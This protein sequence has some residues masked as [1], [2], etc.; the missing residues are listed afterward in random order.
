MSAI[1]IS[2][3]TRQHRTGPA[4]LPRAPPAEPTRGL[5]FSETLPLVID[6][7]MRQARARQPAAAAPGVGQL[8]GRVRSAGAVPAGVRFGSGGPDATS[9]VALAD[10][11]TR[12]GQ[13]SGEL[14]AEGD[15]DAADQ[16]GSPLP[17]SA[18]SRFRFVHRSPQKRGIA[19]ACKV[20]LLQI[21][22]S[23]RFTMT[24]STEHDAAL[25]KDIIYLWDAVQLSKATGASVGEC[26]AG[27]V[28][29]SGAAAF[30]RTAAS[31]Q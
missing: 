24:L 10:V 13:S 15:Q 14:A 25:A 1:D 9:S 3:C 23:R 5:T 27:V 31:L 19:W 4:P 7:E 26:G 21:N 29:S 12:A 8:E 16:H 6:S 17:A 30:Q 28:A 20:K 2:F 11:G 22:P 18:A